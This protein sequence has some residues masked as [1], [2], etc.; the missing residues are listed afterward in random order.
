MAAQ[1]PA[2]VT[3]IVAAVE[4]LLTEHGP[5]TEEQ[6]LV[7]LRHAGIDLGGDPAETLADLLG[8]GDPP[9]VVPLA[10]DRHA[11]LPALL[12]GRVFTH[13]LSTAETEHGLVAVTPDLEPLSALADTAP[14]DRLIDGAPLVEILPDLDPDLLT[15]RGMP[16]DALE[17]APVFLLPPERLRAVALRVGDLVGFHV[18]AA[19]MDIT[20]VADGDVGADTEAALGQR[21]TAILAGRGDGGPEHLDAAVWTACA[22]DPD[23][24]H[25]PLPPLGDLL[26]AAGFACDGE[27]IAPAGFDFGSWRA[28]QRIT[29]I[30]RLHDLDEDEAVAVLVIRRLFEQVA[31]VYDAA[32]AAQRSGEAP[33]SVLKLAEPGPAG[34]TDRLPGGRTRDVAED[35]VVRATLTFLADPDVAAAVLAEALGA[36][37]DSAAALGLFAETLEPMAP[38]AARPA[39]RW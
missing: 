19:G 3:V 31:D 28:G 21:L 24:F 2:T 9:L 12:D 10:D 18:T 27:Q 4:R 36:G 15:E 25:G 17:N 35:S 34:V 33:E 13:R 32:V 29:S 16:V 22:D 37:R 38:R 39:L 6:L 14:Y 20:H 11:L 30:Q 26:D 8:A 1:I 7:G 23:L 5:M